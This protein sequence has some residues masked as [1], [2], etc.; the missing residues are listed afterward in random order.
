M[1]KQIVICL[2]FLLA[3]GS[4]SAQRVLTT[5][6]GQKIVLQAD[7]TW[8]LAPNTKPTPSPAV[9]DTDEADV[10]E[11]PTESKAMMSSQQSR[12]ISR[13][14]NILQTSE[15]EALIAITERNQELAKLL[16]RK[17]AASGDEASEI[18][19]QMTA[20]QNSSK[21]DQEKYKAASEYLE[22]LEKISS[23]PSK[24]IDK[25]LDKLREDVGET[26]TLPAARKTKPKKAKNQQSDYPT[27]FALSEID[28]KEDVYPCEIT[29]DGKD[30][31]TGKSKKEVNSGLLFTFTQEKLKPYFKADDFLKCE[32]TMT[33]VGKSY[34][35]TL[36]IRI[37]S[38]DAY[39]TYGSLAANEELKIEFIDGTKIY[40][41]NIIQSTGEIEAY[42]GHTLYTGIYKFDRDEI[43]ELE[44]KYI[45][46]IGILWST[47]FEQYDV[48]NVDFLMHQVKCLKNG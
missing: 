35:L 47:G 33:K 32:S 48:Y 12:E 20:L 7:G 30:P 11:I 26:F 10:F 23:G 45:D 31:V 38:K 46:T 5:K 13:L 2:T 41:T 8:E 16:E 24:K 3:I 37:K 39:R 14:R 9:I 15:I 21:Q 40:G 25:K 34:F 22:D 1:Q 29:F 27:S 43:K 6:S 18:E 36:Q 19:D 42:S 4:I 28:T 44:K 17:N